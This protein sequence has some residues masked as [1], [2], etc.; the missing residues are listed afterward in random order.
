MGLA[1]AV[2]AEG[3]GRGG[4]EMAEPADGGS[5]FFCFCFWLWV[6]VMLWRGNEGWISGLGLPT[7]CCQAKCFV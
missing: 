2:A 5:I 6:V 4:R 7:R 1:A 3:G